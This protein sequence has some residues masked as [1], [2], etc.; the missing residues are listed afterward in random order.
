MDDLERV[1]GYRDYADNSRAAEVV[2]PEMLSLSYWKPDF[3]AAII[4]A[5]EAVGGF[6][7][8]PDDPVPGHEI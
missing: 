8:Q 4:C 2:G 5:A 6:E 1:L 3:C 7:P